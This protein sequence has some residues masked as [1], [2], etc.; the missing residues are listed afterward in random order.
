MTLLDTFDR[1]HSRAR[2]SRGFAAL[3]VTTRVLLA[4]GFTPSGLTKVLGN[5]LRSILARPAAP[6]YEAGFR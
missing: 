5:R 4:L 3:A 2:R 6:A 1:L